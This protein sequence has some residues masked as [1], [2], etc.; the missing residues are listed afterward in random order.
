[1]CICLRMRDVDLDEFISLLNILIFW[2][3]MFWTSLMF[4]TFYTF[5]RKSVDVEAVAVHSEIEK[6]KLW[7]KIMALVGHQAKLILYIV[8]VGR[9]RPHATPPL[10][11]QTLNYKF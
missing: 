5:E 10:C 6:I 3:C 1:M 7:L 2:L 9:N 8:C 4:S 11:R